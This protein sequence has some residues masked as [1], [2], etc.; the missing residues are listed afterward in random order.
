MNPPRHWE[1]FDVPVGLAVVGDADVELSTFRS[2][3]HP[4]C[5]F[6]DHALHELVEAPFDRPRVFVDTQELPEH[7][8]VQPWAQIPG[9][10]ARLFH[11]PAELFSSSL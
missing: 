3:D 8:P 1:Q 10:D 9:R 11:F 5:H 4:E 6:A 7:Q 2:R